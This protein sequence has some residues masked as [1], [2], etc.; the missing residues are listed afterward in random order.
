MDRATSPE[1]AARAFVRHVRF[2]GKSSR[3]DVTGI[4]C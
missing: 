3:A 1:T 2:N 4:P